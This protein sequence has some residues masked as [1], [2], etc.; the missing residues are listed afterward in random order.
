M[1]R[2]FTVRFWWD[3]VDMANGMIQW[4]DHLITAQV[5]LRLREASEIAND[6]SVHYQI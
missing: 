5:C 1:E 4:V 6:G 3:R 2:E